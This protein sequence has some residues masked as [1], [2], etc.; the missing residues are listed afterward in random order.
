MCLLTL[1][2]VVPCDL[3][4]LFVIGMLHGLAMSCDQSFPKTIGG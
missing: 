2:I 4:A 1:S 3:F